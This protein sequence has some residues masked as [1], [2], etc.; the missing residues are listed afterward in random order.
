M[1]QQLNRPFTNARQR[2]RWVSELD[3]CL[4]SKNVLDALCSFTVHNE[5]LLP[6]NHAPIS[7]SLRLSKLHERGDTT[8][9]MKRATEL[10]DHAVLHNSFP[11]STTRRRQIKSSELNPEAIYESFASTALPQLSGDVN[12][13][14]HEINTLLYN[15]AKN[16]RIQPTTST[17]TNAQ[18][19]RWD[20][21]LRLK[22]PKIL[23]QAINWNGA[24]SNDPR[25]G[26]SEDEFKLHFEDLLNP[27]N[28]APLQ[29]HPRNPPV[30][31]PVTDDR[32]QPGE[33]LHAI[34]K[35][36]MSC[37]G[38]TSGIPPGLL[39]WLPDN[40]SVLMTE[41]FNQVFASGC[42]PSEWTKARLVTIFKKGD[43]MACSNYRG[44]SVIDSLAKVY[45]MVLCSRLQHWFQPDPCQ[46]GAQKKRSCVEHIVSLRLLFDFARNHKKKLFTIFV[47]FSKAYDRVPRQEMIDLMTDTGCG[48]TM[49]AAITAMY[50]STFAIIGS[51]SV[52]SSAGVRQGS[53]SSCFLFT[54]VVDKLLRSLAEQC[55]D[56]G[57]LGSTHALMMMD[58]TVLLSTTR[59]GAEKKIKI[60]QD[61]CNKFGMVINASKTK[62]MANNGDDADCAPFTIPGGEISPFTSD[63]K[64]TSAISEHCHNKMAHVV[65]YCAFVKKNC[66]FPFSVKR[67]VLEAA[68]ISSLLF[69]CESWL[70]ANLGQINVNYMTAVKALLGVRKTTPNDLCLVESG[71]L[72]P[73]TTRVKTAQKKFFTAMF[74][75]QDPEDPFAKVWAIVQDQSPSARYINAVMHED[76]SRHQE[77]L[78]QRVQEATGSRY[79]TYRESINPSL[80]LHPLYNTCIPEHERIAT[81]RLRLSSHSLAVEKGRWSRIPREERLCSCGEGVHDE[82]HVLAN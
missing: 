30:Y 65:K 48:S 58:D 42:Y 69:G 24:I 49:I 46:I 76:I 26:P 77:K 55:P 7:M 4:I 57:F 18:G 12:Q 16:S 9:I 15:V 61:F 64:V 31:L 29:F 19:N 2:E 71:L 38:G 67:T 11:S 51:A 79:T 75:R 73:C 41:I 34:K 40:Y 74:Q 35:L 56:D 59:S 36:K 78:H 39:K 66:D 43:P 25:N 20:S 23:W 3:A 22:D 1:Q 5:R 54:M 28:L 37:S 50:K 82:A 13:S 6:S 68:L 10:G 81:T 17:L 21:L 63:G 27:S 33:V 70:C 62:F 53:P 72:T 14:V 8:A 44:I 47:D 60:L 80:S 32:I 45:D 52:T